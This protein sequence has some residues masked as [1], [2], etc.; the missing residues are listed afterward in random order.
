MTLKL[1]LDA[2]CSPGGI[3][4]SLVRH[5]D[6]R[7]VG[8]LAEACCMWNV[9]AL[10]CRSFDVGAICKSE[11]RPP[12]KSLTGPASWQLDPGCSLIPGLGS[13]SRLIILAG[14]RVLSAVGACPPHDGVR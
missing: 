2:A 10:F 8:L 11:K 5:S 14:S 9:F 13:S 7:S 1:N 12:Q 6:E 4:R 3:D